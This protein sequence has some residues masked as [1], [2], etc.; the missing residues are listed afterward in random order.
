MLTSR[1]LFQN[2]PTLIFKSQAMWLPPLRRGPTRRPNFFKQT[3]QNFSQ[4]HNSTHANNNTNNGQERRRF[5]GNLNSTDLIN[6]L[7]SFNR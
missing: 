2:S 6:Y 7:F 5:R 1:L 4:K 3:K